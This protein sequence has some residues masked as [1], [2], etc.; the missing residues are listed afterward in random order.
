MRWTERVRGVGVRWGRAQQGVNVACWGLGFFL[1]FRCF[2]IDK[3]GG[4]DHTTMVGGGGGQKQM[5]SSSLFLSL[6]LSLFLSLSPPSIYSTV[7]CKKALSSMPPSWLRRRANNFERTAKD[8]FVFCFMIRT[9]FILFSYLYAR[10]CVEFFMEFSF[11]LNPFDVLP[12]WHIPTG[13]TTCVLLL[14]SYFFL[15]CEFQ[16]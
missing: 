15:N 6:S 9:S 2:A 3:G 12:F 16:F 5:S 4:K 1:H 7:V 14:R 13:R 11:F 10:K 8:W